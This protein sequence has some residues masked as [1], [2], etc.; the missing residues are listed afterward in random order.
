MDSCISVVVRE[1]RDT[2]LGG[3]VDKRYLVLDMMRLFTGYKY[4]QN[5]DRNKKRPWD[6]PGAVHFLDV[7]KG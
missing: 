3:I 4:L 7:M 6:W 2:N 1:S 5:A